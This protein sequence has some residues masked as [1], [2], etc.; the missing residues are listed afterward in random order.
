MPLTDLDTG[1]RAALHSLTGTAVHHKRLKRPTGRTMLLT[2]PPIFPKKQHTRPTTEGEGMVIPLLRNIQ[3]LNSLPQA[4]LDTTGSKHVRCRPIGGMLPTLHPRRKHLRAAVRRRITACTTNRNQPKNPARLATLSTQIPISPRQR[5][6]RPKVEREIRSGVT[7]MRDRPPNSLR[8]I[9][10]DTFSRDHLKFTAIRGTIPIPHPR[11]T[12][13]RPVMHM[14]LEHAADPQHR[15]SP[16]EL[17]MLPG[18][19]PVSRKKQRKRVMIRR[20]TTLMSDQPLNCVLRA[21]QETKRGPHIN[22]CRARD[23]LPRLHS[24]VGGRTCTAKDQIRV[25]KTKSLDL[26]HDTVREPQ[27]GL[28]PRRASRMMRR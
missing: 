13:L 12:H 7:G 20:V 28:L 15:R 24:R 5:Y 23:T 14:N 26:R 18:L 19:K 27:W 17:T 10:P 8:R 6:T 11:E 25:L 2:R 21:D 3:P 22:S 1:L 16:I 4:E 9:N